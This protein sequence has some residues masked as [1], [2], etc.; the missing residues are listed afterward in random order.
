VTIATTIPPIVRPDIDLDV[1]DCELAELELEE[2]L[3]EALF[4]AA[5]VV[6]AGDL[7]VVELAE[8]ENIVEN[9]LKV[10]VDDGACN[11]TDC[12]ISSGTGPPA[13]FSTKVQ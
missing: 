10:E 12:N 11:N 2:I 3:P 4:E 5:A 1:A 7:E 6:S 13:V 9:E 8:V